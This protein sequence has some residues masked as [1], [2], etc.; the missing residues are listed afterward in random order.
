MRHFQEAGVAAMIETTVPHHLVKDNAKP[1]A[2][3]F[4]LVKYRHFAQNTLCGS[5]REIAWF[6]QLRKWKP[7]TTLSCPEGGGV[8]R[9]AIS[10][11]RSAG[12]SDNHSMDATHWTSS[13]WRPIASSHAALPTLW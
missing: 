9:C 11:S 6:R 7:L 13:G 3:V 2:L 1:P 10:A 4:W 8:L 12:L 5:K